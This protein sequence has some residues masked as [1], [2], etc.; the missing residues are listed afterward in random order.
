M[1]FSDKPAIFCT[2]FLSGTLYEVCGL[3]P[4]L[5]KC[6][7]HLFLKKCFWAP[8]QI[9][10][11]FCAHTLYSISFLKSVFAHFFLKSADRYVNQ[12]P[13]VGQLFFPY[14]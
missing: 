3:R 14:G 1:Q 5:K 2:L 12:L 9:S 10:H 13:G 4:L 7:A 8:F 6:F 11:A